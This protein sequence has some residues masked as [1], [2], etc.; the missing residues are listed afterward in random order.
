MTPS[1]RT[2]KRGLIIVWFGFSE[3]GTYVT[4]DFT[5]RLIVNV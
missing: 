5:R 3:R 2:K 1:G 4:D